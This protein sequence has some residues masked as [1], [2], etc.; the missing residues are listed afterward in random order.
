M[1]AKF[2]L[3][4]INLI[5][6]FFYGFIQVILINVHTMPFGFSKDSGSHHKEISIV[7]CERKGRNSGFVITDSSFLE[8]I[9]LRDSDTYPDMQYS[10]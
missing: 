7:A 9:F 6:I 10:K 4:G 8:D 5:G 2:G 3:F 1:I